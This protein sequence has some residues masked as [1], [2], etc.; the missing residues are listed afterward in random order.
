M[1]DLYD[2]LKKLVREE[3]GRLRFGELAVVQDVFP[4][5]PGNYDATVT[6]KD[7]QL[8]LEHVPLLSARKGFAS[9]PDAGD[10]VLVQFVGGDLNR[11][12]I[13]GSLYNDEDRPPE[14]AKG[15]AVV[16]LPAGESKDAALRVELNEASPLGLRLTVG[17]ALEIGLSDDDPVVSI[18]V[19]GSATLS[20]E[21]SGA[22]TLTSKADLTLEASQ[23]LEIKA[24]GTL[25]LKGATIN[26]N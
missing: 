20:I 7:S 6:L 10:L 21:R 26:L 5:D 2:T 11:P 25:T 3:L 1:N 8:V 13:V 12:V 16:H 9:V 15:Q 23:N 19:G 24:G 4:T 17:S 18:D 22:I 14:N